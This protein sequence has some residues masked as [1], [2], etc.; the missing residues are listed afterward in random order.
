MAIAPRRNYDEGSRVVGSIYGAAD[1][2][3]RR[4]AAPR[5]INLDTVQWIDRPRRFRY[6]VWVYVIRKIP[7]QEGIVLE[8]VH[9]RVQ[10]L[11]KEQNS[12]EVQEELYGLLRDGIDLIWK[13]TKKRW[14]QRTNPFEHVSLGEF[15][16]IV[17]FYYECR[18]LLPDLALVDSPGSRTTYDHVLRTILPTVWANSRRRL[19]TAGWRVES[20]VV[21]T[22]SE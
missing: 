3:E 16:A 19:D 11:M 8:Y 5:T 22:T 15:F 20:H 6:G 12:R 18:M 4:V 13:L 2:G 7:W 17:G 9:D 10:Q 21:S 14:W 1:P